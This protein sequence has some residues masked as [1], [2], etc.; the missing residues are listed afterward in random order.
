MAPKVCPH[1]GSANLVTTLCQ[2]PSQ[3]HARTDCGDCRRWL[4]WEAAP[5]T[6]ERAAS[7]VMPFGKYEGQPLNLIAS[8]PEGRRYL[9]WC[10]DELKF[11]RGAIRRAIE[12]VLK[13][14]GRRDSA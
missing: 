12:H 6:D 14:R 3:H 9:A 5:M 13:G 1:C 8:N 4:R 11:K 10:L 7:F 2:P